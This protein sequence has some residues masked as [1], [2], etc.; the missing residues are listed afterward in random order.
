M[1]GCDAACVW[2]VIRWLSP[3]EAGG[4]LGVRAARPA[5]DLPRANSA[6]AVYLVESF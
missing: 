5:R 2:G 1:F 6:D 3:T 4:A